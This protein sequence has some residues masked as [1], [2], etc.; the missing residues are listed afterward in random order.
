MFVRPR[1]HAGK[2]AERI[3]L[4]LQHDTSWTLGVRHEPLADFQPSGTER[5][6]RN[7]DLVFRTDS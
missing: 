5:V 6:D 2:L 3:V 7:G 4:A 1:Q